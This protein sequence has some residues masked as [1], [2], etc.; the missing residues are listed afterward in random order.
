MKKR[1]QEKQLSGLETLSEMI[2]HK[3]DFRRVP[4]EPAEW[5][6]MSSLQSVDEI[7]A[8]KLD[9]FLDAER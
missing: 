4:N 5:T 8:N 3:P 2:H 6:T 7:A 1:F 9:G